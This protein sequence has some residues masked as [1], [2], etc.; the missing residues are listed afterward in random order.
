M[1]VVIWAAW[2]SGR[3]KASLFQTELLARR[4]EF[5]RLANAP[6]PR[7]KS[8][9]RVNPDDEITP[10]RRGKRLKVLPG[11]EVRLECFGNV[12]RQ[13]R[14]RRLRRIAVSRRRRS[15]ARRG[16]QACRLEF[17]PASPV[18]IRPLARRLARRDFD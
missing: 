15:E 13:L 12:G 9:G 5:N 3:T 4:E 8:L 18:D 16:K 7:L 11:S 6:F 17:V 14:D 1:T 2:R 10:V